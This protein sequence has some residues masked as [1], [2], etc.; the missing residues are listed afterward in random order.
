MSTVL[1]VV[2]NETTTRNM[3]AENMLVSTRP[4]VDIIEGMK[5]VG[6]RIT[7][8][9]ATTARMRLKRR[10]CGPRRRTLL[11]AVIL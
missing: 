6:M 3:I 7:S 5:V 11:S 10:R 9:T 4:A 8:V 1:A 2:K